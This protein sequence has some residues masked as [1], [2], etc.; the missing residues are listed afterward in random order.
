M[1][2]GVFV[3]LTA[4]LMF[5]VFV[6]VF[7][8]FNKGIWIYYGDFNVQQIPFYIHLH[9][10]I[11]EGNFFYDFSTDLGGGVIGCYSFYILGSPFF[12]LTYPFKN[13]TVVYLIPWINALKYATMAL[14]SY[15]WLKRHTKTEAGAFMGAL[16]YTFSGY[17]GAVLVYNHFHDVMAFFP[18]WLIAFEKLM[19]EKKYITYILMTAFM[20]ILN[21]YFFVGEALFLVIYFFVRYHDVKRLLRAFLASAAGL[22]LSLWY[23]IPAISYTVGNSRLSDV[24]LGNDLVAYSEPTMILGIIKNVMLLPDLSGLNSMFNESY[25]RVSG[26]GAYLPMISVSCVIAYFLIYNKKDYSTEKEKWPIRL[27]IVCAVFAFIPA[28]NA[29]FSA[30]NSEYYARWYFMPILI[31]SLMSVRIL[32]KVPEDKGL[33]VPM[34]YGNTAVAVA[35][36]FFAICAVL[37]AK[38]EEG[39]L[40]ILGSLKSPEQLIFELVFTG[41]LTIVFFILIFV[42]FPRVKSIKPVVL[43]IW[44]ASFMTGLSMMIAG[45]CLVERD[46]QA[47]Y[48]TQGIKGAD[49]VVLPNEDIWCR[50]ETEQ[51]VYNYP[52]IWDRPTVTAFISTVPSS[53]MDFYEGLGLTRK[54]TSKLGVTRVGARTLLS[55]RYLLTERET[56]IEHIGHVE[57]KDELTYFTLIGQTN[58]FDIFENDYFVPMGFSFDEYVSESE[59]KESDKASGTLDKAL[60]QYIIL[61]DEDI[62]KYGKYMKKGEIE[63][64]SIRRFSEECDKRREGACTDFKTSK[65][66]FTANAHMKKTN[67]LFFSVPYDENFTAYVDGKEAGIVKAD[68]GFMAVLVPEGMHKIEF[69]F[70]PWKKVKKYVD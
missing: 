20:A 52:M 6:G 13:E 53:I 56:P 23:L 31:M 9:K 61:S 65:Y 54:V 1:K 48:I 69:K 46:R 25:S 17:S 41:V 59:Y 5:T 30:L 55:S 34:L 42:L 21:Y 24:L 66:G 28:L 14:S 57:D 50:I 32:E 11:K 45:E 70:D 58:G 63:P 38:T 15:L 36:S 2:K 19:E 27:M 43:V 7:L 35:V 22:V 29:L 4:F 10:L 33:K 67:L 44:I 40:T 68:F 49:N 18:L 51:D 26:V 39:G 8:I 60:M 47:N 3:F 64:Y 62:D 37:P 12:W 16:L